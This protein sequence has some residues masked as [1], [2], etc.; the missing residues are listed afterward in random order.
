LQGAPYGAVSVWV[1][2]ALGLVPPALGLIES[3][4]YTLRLPNR[5]AATFPGAGITVTL[6]GR[7]YAG[8]R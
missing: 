1:L 5:L 4:T 8:D 2:L 7:S 6:L 3:F